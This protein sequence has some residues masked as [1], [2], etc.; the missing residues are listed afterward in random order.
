MLLLFASISDARTVLRMK[1]RERNMSGG[2]PPGGA[3]RSP[4]RVCDAAVPLRAPR[5]GGG[6]RA[7]YPNPG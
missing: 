4:A 5:E 3:V 6:G 1:T 7:A 2:E